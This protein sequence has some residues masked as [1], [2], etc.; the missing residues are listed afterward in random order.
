MPEII[1]RSEQ[2]KFIADIAQDFAHGSNSPLG[3]APTG[4]GKTVCLAYMANGA[5]RKGNTVGI[6][7]HRQELITQT[8]LAL[9]A[10]GVHHGIIAPDNVIRASISRQVEAFGRSYFNSDSGVH[11]CS[12]Q[13]AARRIETISP[14]DYIMIDEGHHAVA[15][16]WGTFI[17]AMPQAK[18][19][20]V[21][22]TPERLDGKGLGVA[23]GGCFSSLVMGPTVQELIDVGNLAPPRVFA[24][25]VQYDAAAIRTKG[26][27]FDA[28]SATSSID[29]PTI[30][31]DAISHYKRL[32]DGMPA[33]AFCASVEH[34]KHV[35]DQF[36]ANGYR[37][38]CVEGNM[39]DRDRREAITGLGNGSI[40]VLTSCD[41]VSEGTDIPIVAAAIMLRPTRSLALY[42]QQGGRV[43]RPYKGKEYAASQEL[44]STLKQ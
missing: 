24:P 1:L 27:D 19:L 10:Q 17:G 40:H 44:K 8:S 11:L 32:C 21:T 34:A 6:T 29:K 31:G 23:A 22:A 20:G 35:A 43:L 15:G 13:T 26:G 33:I 25:P 5:R 42:M 39:A 30:T 28:K 9:A 37:S 7:V 3:V 14:F 12:V 36:A 18:M 16:Q 2:K 4:M 38:V 41:I